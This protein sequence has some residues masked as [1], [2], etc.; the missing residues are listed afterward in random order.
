M[1]ACYF[2]SLRKGIVIPTVAFAGTDS[3]LRINSYFAEF[4]VFETDLEKFTGFRDLMAHYVQRMPELSHFESHYPPGF[5]LIFMAGRFAATKLLAKFLTILLP[6]LTIFPIR[7]LA[8]ELGFSE[9]AA[10]LA[11]ALFA[12]SA[13][14]LIFPSITPIGATAFFSGLCL[15]LLVRAL[16]KGDWLSASAFGLS[17]AIYFF[18]SFASYMPGIV[19]AIFLL[20]GLINR[21]IP[22]R[23]AARVMTISIASF[24]LFF[25][26]LYLFF[27]FNIIA[28]FKM[29]S[30][31]HL[32][33]TGHGFDD[34]IRYLFRSTGGIIAYLIST[35]FAI[36]ILPIAAARRS[37]DQPPLAR[38]FVSATLL[39][40]LLAGFSGM[41][42]L[43]T[44]RI[45]VMFTPALAVAAGAELERREQR[46]GKW[47]AFGVILFALT[48][49][50]AYELV[51]RHHL[52]GGAPQS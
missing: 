24:I 12:T 50:C 15:W 39:G 37:S 42:F 18:C 22:L 27:H 10:A 43:E 52:A 46:E 36:A 34:P 6:V 33:E 47:I 14:I 3:L 23:R 51:F 21:S 26:C 40:I 28:C 1:W 11:A 8:R 49:S 44:E 35:S 20:V 38:V 13:G 7:Q 25:L 16:N 17:Y 32:K 19:M 4:R 45:W 9:R 31:M 29:A 30:A 41:S 2:A 5:L 48:F